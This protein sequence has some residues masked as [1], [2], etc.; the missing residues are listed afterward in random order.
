M[1]LEGI[2]TTRNADGGINLAPMGPRIELDDSGKPCFETFLLR[3]FRT[4]LTFA[5]LLR[6]RQG[7]LHVVDDVRLLARAAILNDDPLPSLRP[8]T[9][10]HGAV[11]V[12]CCRFMEFVIDEVDASLDRASF[13]ARVVHAGHVRD[14]FGLNRAKHAIVEAAILATRRHLIDPTEMEEA[15]TRLAPLIK[16]TGGPAEHEA[17]ALLLD[18]VRGG[19]DS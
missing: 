7:V 16:K 13:T 3:P 2:V 19:D 8:A 15:F 12:D 5:N 1:I 10:I 6:E 11:L 18:Y 9:H 14:F 4:S 17:F